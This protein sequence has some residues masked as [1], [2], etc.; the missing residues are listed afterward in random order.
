MA[1][2]FYLIELGIKLAE[3][4]TVPL[5]TQNAVVT[6]SLIDKKFGDNESGLTML[7]QF[8]DR[9][10]R[11]PLMDGNNFKP[12]INGDQAFPDML[13]AIEHAESSITL[14]S[15]IFDNDSWG[16]KFRTALKNAVARGVEVR[17][18]IDSVGARYS[19]PSIIS[20]LRTDGVKVEQF[21]ETFLPW[22]FR[23]LNLRNHRKLMV[24][25]GKT[26]FTG[27]LN[28]REG[29]V[30]SDN[31]P[32]PLQDIHF[33]IQGPIVAQLQ[34][35]FAE[36]WIFTTEERLEGEI[37]F[38]HLEHCGSGMARGLADGPDEDFGKLRLVILGALASARRSIRIASP[39]FLP[40][41]ELT[42]GLIVAAL[43]G[44]DVEIIVPATT[45]LRLVKWASEACL[46]EL[47]EAGCRIFYSAPPFDHSK[48]MV[49]DE[50]WV[51]LGSANWDSRSLTLNFEFNIECYDANLAYLINTILN[52][53]IKN[54]REVTRE[55]M[56]SRFIGIQ[57]RNRFLR[58]FSPYL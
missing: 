22:R 6:S 53:K 55:E 29:V 41:N 28:I 32:Y 30:L 45:N 25:D 8:T 17:V 5:P 50:G 24:V 10:T 42:T 21:M 4:Q 20:G 57:L 33:R 18:L 7:A 12:L 52:E 58:L 34:C 15:Y 38:P 54:S 11:Q 51:L 35:T 23:Y 14:C 40:D 13:A 27:G 31:P 9:V 1:V 19:F 46:D 36:D 48:L 37:W 43:R 49:V 44:V 47:L 2:I 39:Y 3:K 56:K 26:G 16:K